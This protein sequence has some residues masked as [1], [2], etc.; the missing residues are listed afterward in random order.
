MSFFDLFSNKKAKIARQEEL[1][2]AEIEKNV[3]R[4]NSSF[5]QQS[6]RERLAKFKMPDFR[7]ENSICDLFV[8]SNLGIIQVVQYKKV[9]RKYTLSTG[10]EVEFPMVQLGAEKEFKFDE[11]VGTELDYC[12]NNLDRR[13]GQYYDCYY[14]TIKLDSL[15]RPLYHLPIYYHESQAKKIEAVVENIVRRKTN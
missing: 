1:E 6:R 9:N 10:R 5:H 3:K 14:V 4:H 11:I 2:I 12:G 13:D 7:I 15:K 8:Y